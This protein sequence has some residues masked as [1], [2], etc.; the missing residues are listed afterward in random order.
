M[1]GLLLWITHCWSCV[2]LMC[3]ARALKASV[4]ASNVALKLNAEHME[5]RPGVNPYLAAYLM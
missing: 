1:V 4:A 5:H 2:F 3:N